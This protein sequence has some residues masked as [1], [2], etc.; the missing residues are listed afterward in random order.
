MKIELSEVESCVKKITIEVP[1]ERVEQEKSTVLAD[2]AKSANIPGYRKGKAPKKILEKRYGKSAMGDVIQRLIQDAYRQALE[3]NNLNPVGDPVIED[4][5]FEENAPLSFSAMVEVLPEVELKEYEGVVVKKKVAQATDEEV[6]KTIGQFRE[7]LARLEPVEDRP[8]ADEDYVI[9]DFRATRDGKE[10][11]PLTGQGKQVHLRPDDMLEVVYSGIRGMNKGEEKTFTAVLPKEF[12]DPDL[13]EATIEFYVKVNEIKKKALPELDDALAQEV[14]EFDTMEGFRESIQRSIRRR[15]E[16]MAENDL[17]QEVVAMLI[18]AN[19]FD[20]PP[21]MVE[22][23]TQALAERTEQ[24]FRESGV[25]MG[26]SHYNR[27][28]F[29]ERFRENAEREIREEIILASAAKKEKVEVT[30]AD[31]AREISELSRMVG[32]PE[33]VVKRQLSQSDGMMG[34]YQKVVFDKAYETVLGKLKIEEES[35]ES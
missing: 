22:R 3:K 26:Q 11:A 10:I 16:A 21:R 27:A 25:E 12:P 18:A 35:K 9:I 34:L 31:M 17:R 7:R 8:A 13:A 29:I 32:Q 5:S 23:R 24:R 4:V 20:L 1:L 15:N 6:D 33:D 19:T 30:E 28:D 14:S 2:L